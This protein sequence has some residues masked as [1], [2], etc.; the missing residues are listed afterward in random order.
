MRRG[1]FFRK[2]KALH[3]GAL[4]M[5]ENRLQTLLGCVSSNHCRN[6]R[7]R[8]IGKP[9]KPAVYGFAE[10]FQTMSTMVALMAKGKIPEVVRRYCL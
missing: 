4:V 9:M 3:V 10:V 8:Y 5:S 6:Y 7:D 1:S 2:E